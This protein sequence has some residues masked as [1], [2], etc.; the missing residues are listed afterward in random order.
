MAAIGPSQSENKNDVD[1]WTLVD[2][3]WFMKTGAE[4]LT[5][6]PSFVCWFSLVSEGLQLNE[7][8]QAQETKLL[9]YQSQLRVW[10][11]FVE[12]SP[13]MFWQPVCPAAVTL[14]FRPRMH[15]S[16]R[17]FGIPSE[18]RTHV[19]ELSQ[20]TTHA[21]KSQVTCIACSACWDLHRSER[22]ISDLLK[23]F[24]SE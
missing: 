22:L 17:R 9:H 12:A 10:G 16:T 20:Q 23:S 8:P 3:S 18:T 2:A 11:A 5:F 19:T 13:V 4:T 7:L 24:S 1:L 21:R 15:P 14:L 6:L